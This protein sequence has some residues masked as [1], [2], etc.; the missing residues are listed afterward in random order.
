MMASRKILE[1]ALIGQVGE[2]IHQRVLI[3]DAG[4]DQSVNSWD[5]PMGSGD[6]C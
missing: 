6:N 5:N 4:F 3:A 2:K 1:G